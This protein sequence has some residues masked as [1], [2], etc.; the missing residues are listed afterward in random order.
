MLRSFYILLFIPLGWISVPL[1]LAAQ[2][3]SGDTYSLSLEQAESRFL[4][5]NLDLI[6]SR[7]QID[8][9][10]AG[11]I[12]A[13]LFAN[14]EFSFENVFYNPTSKKFFETSHDGGQYQAQLSQLIQT[15]G[16]RNKNIQ[17]ARISAQQSEY[18]FYDLM[19]TLR[20]SLRSNFYKLYYQQQSAA[21]YEKEI[22][23]LS[24]TLSVFK[25]QYAKGNIAQKEL[26]RI[27]SQL[28]SL[29]AE[30]SELL[31]DLEDTKSELKIL[32]HVSANAEIHPQIDK[33][34]VVTKQASAV[35]YQTLIDSA[36]VNR[37]DLKLAKSQV[38]YNDVNLRLQKAM[39][40]PDI[41]ASVAFDKQGSYIRNYNG[42][43]LAF[44]LPFFNRNQGAIKQA[45]IAIDASK[46]ALEQQQ[47]AIENQIA[48]SYKTALRVENLT[49]GF[50]PKFTEDFTKLITEVY[51]NY[52]RH[53]I[54]L[55]EFID[56]YDS[57]KSNTLQMNNLA[58]Q[59]LTSLEEL[60]F[61]TGS[62]I[63]NK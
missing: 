24:A 40:V 9:A 58:L 55:L 15:A 12:T 27:Q 51:K 56:F 8:E 16:K 46:S 48:N 7:Y 22:S 50:D 11:I 19:R 14:P 41:T 17:L 30:H 39:A 53:N 42:L 2:E 10:K 13:R 44:S 59:R 38:D 3:Q 18:Q 25:Q 62:S 45:R 52:Q 6:I 57:F 23:S 49:N 28:Y 61:L 29:Q 54:S 31:D 47:E 32:L 43:G 20:Y 4:K 1:Q 60:N 33:D 5:E 26:L 36:L 35:P 21:I 37:S 63:F 34:A